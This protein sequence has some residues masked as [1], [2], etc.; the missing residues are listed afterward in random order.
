M[1][2]ENTVEVNEAPAKEK[3]SRKKYGVDATTF[4][5]AWQGANSVQEVADK[6]NMPKNIVQARYSLYKKDGVNLKK[7]ERKSPKKLD[8][9][10]L[11]ELIGG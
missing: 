8:V 11:N 10:A 6:L 5:T 2:D 3:K 9:A 1:S 7:M 4:V